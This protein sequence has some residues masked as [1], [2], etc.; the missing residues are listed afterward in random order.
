LAISPNPGRVSESI[1]LNFESQGP[2]NGTL[3]VFDSQGQVVQRQTLR[4]TDGKNT[5][6]LNIPQ[7]AKGQY[8]LRW[9]DYDGLVVLNQ[10]LVL[11]E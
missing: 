4:L 8:I 2:K 10:R 6:L 5:W 11:I 7:L 3:I 1:W 9:E